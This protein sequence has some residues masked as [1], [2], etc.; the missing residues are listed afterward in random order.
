MEI[1]LLNGMALVSR[2][3]LVWSDRWESHAPV[4]TD[5]ANVQLFHIPKGTH[6][7]E[8]TWLYKTHLMKIIAHFL[9]TI[10][11]CS[12]AFE[13]IYKKLTLFFFKVVRICQPED[14]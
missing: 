2:R 4:Q 3:R 1:L 12:F 11:N 13:F 14:S 5:Y 7:R 9:F 8:N 10:V 6:F